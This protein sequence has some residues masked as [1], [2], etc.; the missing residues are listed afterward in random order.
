MEAVQRLLRGESVEQVSREL[1]VTAATLSDWR[2]KALDG[3]RVSLKSRA[4]D[5]AVHDDAVGALQA[6]ARGIATG[7]CRPVRTDSRSTA[8]TRICG[9]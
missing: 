9:S 1:K 4:G 3:A 2:E 5:D 6:I 7:L 8:A